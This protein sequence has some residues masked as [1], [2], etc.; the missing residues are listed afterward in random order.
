MKKYLPH[1]DLITLGA[2]AI[3]ILLR[4][5]LLGIGENEKGL[6]PANHISWILL[7]ILSIALAASLFLL[8]AQAGKGRSYSANFSPSLTGAVGYAVAG[9]GM[10]LA[11]LGHLS[12]SEI[13]L[14]K[15]TGFAGLVAAAAL[16]LGGYCRWKG[17]TPHFLVFAL[18]C[19][20][21]ALRLFC[22]GHTWGDEPELHRFLL[23]FFA[24]AACVL[25]SYQLWAFAVG[26][27][28]RSAS[29]LWSLLATY[30]CLVAAPGSSDGLFYLTAAVWLFTNLCPK[31][32]APFRP[33]FRPENE[34]PPAQE[35][36]EASAEV[37]AEIPQEVDPEIEA[38][39]AELRL[40]TDEMKE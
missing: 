10:I 18:P 30:L 31:K 26:L 37:P 11:A 29:L 22:M 35:P 34:V 8:A 23:G 39:I 3:G 6:Y 14:Y 24:T 27:G 1:I 25:A 17:K 4:L 19:A 12:S 9:C 2:S 16:I 32:V 40:K 33:Q 38:I 20:Y 36:A 13:L 7:L 15:I 5:W 28:N 21:F